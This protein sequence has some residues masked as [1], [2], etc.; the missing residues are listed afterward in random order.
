M[1]EGAIYTTEGG[2]GEEAI[3][4]VL[5]V[6]PLCLLLGHL[7]FGHLHTKKRGLRAA[8]P[9]S[10]LSLSLALSICIHIYIYIERERVRTRAHAS[11]GAAP[12]PA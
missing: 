12:S 8:A 9:P 10:A 11:C 3:E 5:L 2:L 6:V 1:L 4:L 7:N